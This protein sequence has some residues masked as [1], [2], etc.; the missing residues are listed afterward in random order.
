MPII[1]ATTYTSIGSVPFL[2]LTR[3]QWHIVFVGYTFYLGKQY[4]SSTIRSWLC[5][6]LKQIYDTNECV[7][8]YLLSIIIIITVVVI[9]LY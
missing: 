3:C 5:Y 1:T 6:E 8:P 9:V 7:N 2:V 4:K